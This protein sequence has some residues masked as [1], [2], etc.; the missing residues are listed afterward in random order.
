MTESTANSRDAAFLDTMLGSANEYVCSLTQAM[1][2]CRDCD[3]A[4]AASVLA[5]VNIRDCSLYV[6]VKCPVKRCDRDC[7]RSVPA[8]YTL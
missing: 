6:L 3:D 1:D 2:R 4:E 7:H 8:A 5:E